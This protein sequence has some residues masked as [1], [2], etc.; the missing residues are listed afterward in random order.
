MNRSL[1]ALLAAGVAAIPASAMTLT[2]P[3]VA[4][5][6]PFA[7]EQIHTDCGG[8]NISPALSWAGV[9]AGTKTLALTMIDV[10]VKPA[11]W[12][13]WILIGMPPSLQSLPRG[14]WNVPWG[15]QAIRSNYGDL[16]YAGPCP[17]EGSGVHT[18]E[19]TIWALRENVSV[20]RNAKA[21]AVTAT[22]SAA[23]IDKAT[24][25]GTAGR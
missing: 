2:S 18:Y 13:H 12:S 17:P 3:D 7:K 15:A 8:G 16:G 14:A 21:A 1:I 5:G 24:L 23:A 6:Q 11:G 22:L 19:F 9:P 10:S 4:E 20:R 25:T